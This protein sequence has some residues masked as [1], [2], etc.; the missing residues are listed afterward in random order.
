MFNNN[1]NTTTNIKCI[2]IIRYN[3]LFLQYNIIISRVMF[4]Y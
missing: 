2:I 3:I 4:L 1:N